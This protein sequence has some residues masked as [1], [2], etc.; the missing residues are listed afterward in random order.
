MSEQYD[1]HVCLWRF[2][3]EYQMRPIEQ[4]KMFHQWVDKQLGNVGLDR[5]AKT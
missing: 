1:F 4:I 5:I 2:W 3:N